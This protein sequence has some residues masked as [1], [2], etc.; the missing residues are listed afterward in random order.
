MSDRLSIV[1][2]RNLNRRDFLRAVLYGVS[3]MA[4]GGIGAYAV[5]ADV[6]PGQLRVTKITIG[7]NGLPASFEGYRIAHLTD[8]HFGP[9]IAYQTVV[10]GVQAVLDMAPDLIVLTGDYVTYW[11]DETLLRETSPASRRA[12]WRLGGDG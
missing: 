4:L 11:L 1:S 5:D 10:A 9:A 8:I 12:G 2:L 3:G 7:L 6:E